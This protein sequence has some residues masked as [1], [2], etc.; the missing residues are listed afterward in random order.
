[1]RSSIGTFCLCLNEADWI[2]PHILSILPHVDEMV[3]Y[4]GGSDDGTL[5]IIRE[6]RKLAGG[7]KIKLF[8]DKDP[9]D[10]RGDYVKLSNE[11]MWE[12]KTEFAWFCHPDMFLVKPGSIGEA[13]DLPAYTTNL[14]SFA[15]TPGQE[16]RKITSGRGGVWKNMYRLRNPDLGAHYWGDYGAA[17]EDVYFSKITGDSHE[18]YGQSIDRYPYQIGD[19]KALLYH[20]SDVRTKKRRTGRMLACLENQGVPW[21]VAEKEA[22]RHARVTLKDGMGFKFEPAEYPIDFKIMYR[23]FSHLIRG[24]MP[25][26]L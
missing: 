10:L 20:F 9:A 22:P 18:F 8:E 4:D 19:S 24:D 21:E 16:I 11:A 2:G 23:T 17:N 12:L 25:K 5:E 3:F 26:L 7:G 13:W 1:M 6:C 14:I 15:G